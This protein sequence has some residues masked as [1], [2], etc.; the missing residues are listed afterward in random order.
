MLLSLVLSAASVAAAAPADNPAETKTPAKAAAKT[1]TAKTPTRVAGIRT[2]F[3]PSPT[4]PLCAIRLVFQ[5]GSVD[6][7]AGKEGLSAL[8]AQMIGRTGRTQGTPPDAVPTR[9]GRRK[10]HHTCRQ[11]P[12]SPPIRQP[13]RR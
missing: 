8:T 1:P 5:I 4:S 2:V 12:T 9:L 11:H 13:E 10:E 7:P 6:D 3:I